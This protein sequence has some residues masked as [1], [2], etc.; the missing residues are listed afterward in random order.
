MKF[1]AEKL[2]QISRPMTD[3]EREEIEYRDENR[4]WLAMSADFALSL[5]QILRT[6]HITQTELASRMGVSCAQVTKILS[7]KENLGLQT[8]AKVEK[9]IGRRII[10]FGDCMEM[11]PSEITYID[12]EAPIPTLCAEKDAQYGTDSRRNH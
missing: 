8:I 2:K 1:N 11:T 9:A 6:E 5:R 3:V 4:D 10:H 7:G 12:N